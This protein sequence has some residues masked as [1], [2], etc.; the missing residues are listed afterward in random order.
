MPSGGLLC[1]CLKSSSFLVC[2]CSHLSVGGCIHTLEYVMG[3]SVC[4]TMLTPQHSPHN[5]HHTA[6]TAQHS[7]HSIHRTALTTQHSPHLTHHTSLTTQHSPHSTHHTVQM[8]SYTMYIVCIL[9][10]STHGVVRYFCF[11]CSLDVIEIWDCL[12]SDV[13]RYEFLYY[14]CCA[15]IV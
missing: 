12:F 1:S 5:T 11:V 2:T 8:S 10:C 9:P 3:C 6:L 13:N 4:S 15:M 7:P 14:I